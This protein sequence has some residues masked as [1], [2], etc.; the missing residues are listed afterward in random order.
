MS[1][2]A[3]FEMLPEGS[4]PII[5]DEKNVLYKRPPTLPLVVAWGGEDRGQAPASLKQMRSNI[6]TKEERYKAL[7]YYLKKQQLVNINSISF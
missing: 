4:S 3:R 2:T 7:I 6:C 1:Y 5:K